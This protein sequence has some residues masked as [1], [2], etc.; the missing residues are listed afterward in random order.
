MEGKA[1]L[2]TKIL[3]TA[4]MSPAAAWAASVN[5][6]PSLLIIQVICAIA[7]SFALFMAILRMTDSGSAGARRES[8]QLQP[9][10]ATRRRFST[11]GSGTISSST[12]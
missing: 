1:M 12:V 4:S 10:H 7:I 3:L 9:I 6:G 11:L 8:V 2:K 5:V